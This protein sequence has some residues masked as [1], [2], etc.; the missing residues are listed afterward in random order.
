MEILMKNKLYIIKIFYL[1]ISLT[2][3]CSCDSYSSRNKPKKEAPI[4]FSK[5][6]GNQEIAE[7]MNI[8]YCHYLSCMSKSKLLIYL[9]EQAEDK[10]PEREECI[11]EQD[12]SE[13]L[14]AQLGSERVK[15]NYKAAESCNQFVSES[16]CEVIV[17][18]FFNNCV[19]IF[20]GSQKEGNSCSSSSECG[21]YKM[22]CDNESSKCGKCNKVVDVGESCEE[23]SCVPWAIC[24]NKTKECV[25]NGIYKFNKGDICTQEGSLGG[26]N[27]FENLWCVKES[28]IPKCK[29]AE[30]IANKD[31]ECSI[32]LGKFC[33]NDLIC[34][35]VIDKS[36]Y[37]LL[38]S[39]C[40]LPKTKGE[41]CYT[42]SD[43]TMT[44]FE[45][46]N[47]LYCNNDVCIEKVKE[48]EKCA[49]HYECLN[50]YCSKNNICS[51]DSVE[52]QKK[53]LL[54]E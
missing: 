3:I 52:K 41:K 21:D 37:D 29:E 1:I 20:N 7:W 33:D 11:A 31:E 15:L 24:D 45:C 30:F 48:E 5:N 25:E 50:G 19:E 34:P 27:P 26:C 18:E 32:K 9:S 49:H 8:I 22:V 28:N 36:N 54:C 4:Q 14:L 16:S 42:F 39:K 46:E 17:T 51:N 23:D 6:M 53:W 40:A 44:E 12:I 38:P 35:M 10:I 13:T 47:G 2:L 43:E